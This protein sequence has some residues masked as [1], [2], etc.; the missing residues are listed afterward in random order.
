MIVYSQWDNFPGIIK[1][2]QKLTERGV[3]A[4]HVSKLLTCFVG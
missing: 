1:L 4:Y 2:W 3:D